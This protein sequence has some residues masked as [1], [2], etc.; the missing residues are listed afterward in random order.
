MSTVP[1][2]ALSA[3]QLRDRFAEGKYWERL[4]SGELQEL[5]QDEA[6]PA[7]PRAREPICTLSQMIAYLDGEGNKVALVHQY[8]RTG[9]SL[10]GSGRPDPKCLLAD[11]VL[12]FVRSL[13]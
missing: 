8:R 1:K 2:V 13:P 4:R 3:V 9:G 11:G 12:Y 6:H 7:P 5:L 10:G